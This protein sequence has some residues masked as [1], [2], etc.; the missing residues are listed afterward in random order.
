MQIENKNSASLED[1]C[2]LVLFFTAVF[3][4][5]D[6]LQKL[7]KY[8]ICNTDVVAVKTVVIAITYSIYLTIAVL[9]IMKHEYLCNL[10]EKLSMLICVPWILLSW[11]FS[12]TI[13]FIT[14]TKND[15]IID[16]DSMRGLD[17]G[18]GMA[19]NYYHG[20]L[21]IILPSLGT[22]NKGLLEKIQNVE[23]S[24]NIAVALHKLIIL[25]PMSTY[26][27]P[28]LK[29]TSYQWMESAI[30]LEEEIRD[31]AGVKR[32][33]YRNVV[34]KIYPDGRKLNSIP[35]YVVAEGATPVLTFFEALRCAHNETNIYRKYYKH[36][37]KQFYNKLKELLD[38][39]PECKD[40]CELIY[41]DDCDTNG[42]KV[43]VAKVILERLDKISKL[44]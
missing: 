23:D 13:N 9:I 40:L 29:E 19:F 37:I 2:V 43:N 41:Y 17:Y 8:L 30:H 10:F 33:T 28:D 12:K 7:C 18:T 44:H 3:W 21:R 34:Y 26:I 1:K 35:V 14:Q 38:N 25:I 39:D 27:S 15:S 16:I 42:A 5:G 6:I 11:I 32:R 31:R 20:Y 22:F 24:H 36:I 4:T